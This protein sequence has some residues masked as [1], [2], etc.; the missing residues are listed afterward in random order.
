MV[1]VK[2]TEFSEK[3]SQNEEIVEELDPKM[4]QVANFKTIWEHI[5]SNIYNEMNKSIEFYETSNFKEY[6]THIER[7]HRYTAAFGELEQEISKFFDD[8]KQTSGESVSNVLR[9][10]VQGLVELDIYNQVHVKTNTGQIW[11]TVDQYS[12]VAKKSIRQREKEL[13]RCPKCDNNESKDIIGYGT[14]ILRG[15]KM[16]KYQCR[17]CRYTGTEE[18]F[19]PSP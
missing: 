9:W 6:T 16:R 12:V 8:V 14:K 4:E 5:T 3:Y 11:C 17:N 13:L 2:K 18:K 7:L 1:K 19:K 15:K 10:W